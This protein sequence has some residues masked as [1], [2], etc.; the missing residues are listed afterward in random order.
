MFLGNVMDVFLDSDKII[1]KLSRQSLESI[2]E[3]LKDS[4]IGYCHL[5]D[6]ETVKT[7]FFQWFDKFINDIEEEPEYFINNK[8]KHFVNSLPDLENGAYQSEVDYQNA[9]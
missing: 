2:I 4:E 6:D 8:K 1:V 3:R 9:A 7:A 5:F